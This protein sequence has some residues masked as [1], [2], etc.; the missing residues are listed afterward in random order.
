MVAR[1]ADAH[2]RGVERVET[3]GNGAPEL[4]ADDR[5]GPEWQMV[6]MLLDGS[7]REHDRVAAGFDLA[8]QLGPRQRVEVKCA[9][10][11]PPFLVRNGRG[12]R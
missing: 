4:V 1:A 10:S 12:R 7:E 11:D 3:L 5:V 9:H 2:G 8:S 6:T